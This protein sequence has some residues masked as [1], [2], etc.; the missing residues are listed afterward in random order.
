MNKSNFQ[1]V[2][3]LT[4]PQTHK[5]LRTT[6]FSKLTGQALKNK[7][8][9]AFEYP[10]PYDKNASRGNEPYYPILTSENIAR[11]SAC[12]SKL[13]KIKNV[14]PCGRLADYKYYNMDKVIMR[15]FEMFEEL[16]PHL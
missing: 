10:V 3:I 1:P 5:Y 8:V 7:T 11:N 12:L 15:T 16:K 9:V 4:Y 14:F 6:E 2:V 13:K